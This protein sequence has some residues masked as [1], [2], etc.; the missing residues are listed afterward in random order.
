MRRMLAEGFLRLRSAGRGEC[1]LLRNQ[2]TTRGSEIAMSRADA[3]GL[4]RKK[5][6]EDSAACG[7]RTLLDAAAAADA[8]GVLVNDGLADPQAKARTCGA[9]GGEEGL[10][11]AGAS[12][13]IHAASRICHSDVYA[14][15][16]GERI[17]PGCRAQHEASAIAMHGVD[18]IADEVGQHL[19]DLALVGVQKRHIFVAA[20]DGDGIAAQTR[21]IERDHAVQ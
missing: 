11:D 4:E 14:L 3:G 17:A 10:K 12:G 15:R 2:S 21:F 20:L 8:S 1:C 19:A 5:D 9:L 18:G 16:P 13:V 6:A 7:M